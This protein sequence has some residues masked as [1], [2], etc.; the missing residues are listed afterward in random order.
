MEH[1]GPSATARRVAAHRLGFTR[2]ATDYG[3]PAADEALAA[4]VVDGLT[5]P[6][7]RM[8]DYLA[9]RTSFFDRTVTGAIDHGVRQVVVGA[10]GYDGRSLRYAR[11]GVRWFEIDHP[12]T[13]RDKLAR[14]ERLG[15]ATAGVRFAAADFTRDPVAGRLREAGLDA[16]TPSLFLLEGV[17]VYLEPAVLENVLDQFR[18]VAAPRQRAGHQRVRVPPGRPEPGP[19]PGRGRRDGGAGPVHLRGRP[20]P[21]T[22]SPG[23]AGRLRTPAG[24]RPRGPS[25]SARPACSPRP[26]VPSHPSRPGKGVCRCRLCCP[27]RSSRSRSSSTTRPSTISRTAPPTTARPGRAPGPGWCRSSCTRTA[28]GTSPRGPSPSA[29]SKPAPAPGPTWTACGAGVTSPSTGPLK[30]ST[31]ASRARMPSCAPPRPGCGRVRSGRR[32]PA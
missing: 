14:L 17:A 7:G 29:S 12:A 21:R 5:V 10:A 25:A 15:I 16:D 23:P 9:A 18:Q 8:H 28:C 20:R 3:D 6:A 4:D 30:R 19:L 24:K 11:P 2:V 13:Q 27:R 31:R 32:C 22:C 26:P 1:G